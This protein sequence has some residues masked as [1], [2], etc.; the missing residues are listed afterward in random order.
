MWVGKITGL[1]KGEERWCFVVPV[2]KGGD[3]V[4]GKGTSD[5]K[6]GE[7]FILK[8]GSRALV[9]SILGR[10]SDHADTK[11]E[12]AVHLRTSGSTRY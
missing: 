3:G 10:T 8:H 7:W 12:A 4:V 11:G 2:G 5:Q 6:R 9:Y 1:E